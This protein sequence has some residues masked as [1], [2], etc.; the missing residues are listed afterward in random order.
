MRPPGIEQAADSAALHDGRG[1]AARAVRARRSSLVLGASRRR[2]RTVAASPAIPVARRGVDGEPRRALTA[3]MRSSGRAWFLEMVWAPL[4]AHADLGRGHA[5]VSPTVCE[6]I[7][8]DALRLDGGPT[9]PV[10]EL[11]VQPSR[12]LE[13]P[14]HLEGAVDHPAV[15]TQLDRHASAA[16]TLRVA[17]A[18][19]AQ[20]VAFLRSR[21]ASRE[22]RP[23]R[24]QT[25]A[26]PAAHAGRRPPAGTG[27][28]TN[29]TSRLRSH[30][31]RRTRRWT[32]NWRSR[33]APD[34]SAPETTAAPSP[35]SAWVTVAARLPPELSPATAGGVCD[36]PSATASAFSHRAVASAS[37]AVA[38]NG[39]SGASRHSGDTSRQ[40]LTA[41]SS[42]NGAS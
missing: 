5:R 42:R 21:S 1:R 36:A 3:K 11:A 20:R 17:L 30:S 13:R 24:A 23:G 38:G 34:R 4:P 22:R 40:P 7:A 39:C 28:N 31:P 25:G 12:A 19:V 37:S 6:L 9:L 41:A 29:A 15:A 33:R 32:P 26:R 10:T 14:G 2:H 35:A 18:V 8:C 16:Q 27:R